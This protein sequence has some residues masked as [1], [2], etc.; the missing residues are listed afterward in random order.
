MEK[1]IHQEQVL[2]A[3]ANRRRIAILAYLKSHT[4]ST[5]TDIAEAIQLSVQTT[6]KHLQIL[7]SAGIVIDRRRGMSVSYRISLAQDEIL[8]PL[9]RS[10]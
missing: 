7:R 10:L 4:T 2:K 1:H 9:L 3:A 5:V 8:K 6:S